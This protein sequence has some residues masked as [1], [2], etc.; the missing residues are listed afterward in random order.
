MSKRKLTAAF[1]L[2][3]KGRLDCDRYGDMLRIILD[4]GGTHPK[5]TLAEKERLLEGL[6]ETRDNLQEAIEALR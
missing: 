6:C 4:E 3:D 1:Y 5:L 2:V